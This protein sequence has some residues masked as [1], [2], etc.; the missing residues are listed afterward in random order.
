VP[1][2]AAEPGSGL[3]AG[4]LIGGTSRRLGTP[5]A[6]LEID[7]ET[8]LER[9]VRVLSSRVERVVLLGDGPV[10]PGLILP[11]LADPPGL[12]GPLAGIVAALRSD[13]GAAWI[14]AACDQ[15]ALSEEALDWLLA[16]RTADTRAILP[17]VDARGVEPLLALYE[18]GALA[19]VEDLVARGLLAPS[20]LADDPRCATPRVPAALAAAWADIDTP[21]DWERFRRP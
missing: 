18:P 21:G 6:L 1:T 17:R 13:P 9:A 12:A 3:R 2:P 20:R 15:P 8:L 7:G 14:V 5:K 16:Q 10:P 11:R 4:V 19:L